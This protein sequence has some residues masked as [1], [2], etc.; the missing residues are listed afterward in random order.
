V[1]GKFAGPELLET[2]ETTHRPHSMR[3]QP[4]KYTRTPT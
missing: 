3:L 2:I 4:A 1:G